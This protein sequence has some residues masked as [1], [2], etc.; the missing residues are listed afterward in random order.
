MQTFTIN[1]KSY[2]TDNETREVLR[3]IMQS[4]KDNNDSSAVAAIMH[5]GLESGRIIEA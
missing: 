4:A 5:L 1:G 3:S 2:R